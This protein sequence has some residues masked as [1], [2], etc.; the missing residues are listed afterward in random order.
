MP[1]GCHGRKLILP[2]FDVGRAQQ[3]A[4]AGEVGTIEK[5][6]NFAAKKIDFPLKIAHKAFLT[7]KTKRCHKV[8]FRWIGSQSVLR[9]LR[10]QVRLSCACPSDSGL[11]RKLW[12]LSTGHVH[13]L[14]LVRSKAFPP[15]LNQMNNGGRGGPDSIAD[16]QSG[17]HN[18]R[19]GQ[20]R[21]FVGELFE[22]ALAVFRG[23]ERCKVTVMVDL[24]VNQADCLVQ[25]SK[26]VLAISI[27]LHE[28][29]NFLSELYARRVA[30]PGVW[31]PIRTE[32][33]G[34]AHG[35][36]AR[37]LNGFR[38]VMIP[39]AH[40][41]QSNT[42]NQGNG[43]QDRRYRHG[44]RFLVGELNGTYVGDF[45]LVREADSAHGK[46]DDSEDNEENSDNRCCFHRPFF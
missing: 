11:R 35:R 8:A 39:G 14:L 42:R 23:G 32:Y 46:S 21:T 15:T 2:P 43:A 25:I 12:P 31:L 9:L 20:R 10:R 4:S 5:A 37:I 29:S 26:S 34:E 30:K 44:I 38:S 19:F 40:N 28:P 41:H 22:Y 1:P 7:W 6:D 3:P 36:R 13:T 18:D 24:A 45:L 16:S 17:K 33:T 27:C